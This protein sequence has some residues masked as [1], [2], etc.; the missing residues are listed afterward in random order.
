MEPAPAEASVEARE[1]LGRAETE[2]SMRASTLT[3]T[4]ILAVAST[5]SCSSSNAPNGASS[6]DASTGAKADASGSIDLDAAPG[7]SIEHG[8]FVDYMTLKPVAGLT[9]ADNGLTTTTDANG[10]W[11]LTVPSGSLLQPTIT[12]DNKTKLLFPDATA[13][14]SDVDFGT[15]VMPDHTAY[16]LEQGTLDSFDSTKA[17]VQIVVMTAGSC[18]SAVG[19]T[20]SVVSPPGA[21]M[22]YFGSGGIPDKTITSF[23]AVKPNR[24]VAVV[25]NIPLDAELTVAVT[26]PTCTQAPFPAAQGGKTLSSHVRLQAAEPDDVN[27]AL[28]LVLQ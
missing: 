24:A 19:G 17:L 8:T 6:S 15:V 22:V 23:Q 16:M 10:A 3:L 12:G 28:V 21:P 7:T 1:A 2:A 18:A 5:L 14:T 25:Y 4:S 27:S 9:I 11:S 26:H 20:L 13:S